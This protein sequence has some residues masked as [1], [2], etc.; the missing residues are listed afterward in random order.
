MAGNLKKLKLED[1]RI[2][3]Y[4]EYGDP[5]GIPILYNHG[6]LCGRDVE[7]A[8]QTALRMGVRII[9]PNR[10]GVGHSA[11]VAS[12]R[13]SDW[14]KDVG[15]LMDFLKI[16]Q[17]HVL[18]WSMGAPY[19]LAC[20]AEFSGRIRSVTIIGGVLPLDKE[21]NLQQ[22]GLGVQGYTRTCRERPGKAA[23]SFRLLRWL[24]K[25]MPKS[26]IHIVAQDFSQPDDSVIHQISIAR[27]CSWFIEASHQVPGMIEEYVAWAHPWGFELS[28]IF[29]PVTVYWA[30]SDQVVPEA[31]AKKI[32]GDVPRGTYLPQANGGHFFPLTRWEPILQRIIAPV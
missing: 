31:W 24:A 26:F 28:E 19:A 6:N 4:R 25:L 14:P 29:A 15:Q 20:G 3:A 30:P 23:F 2:L 16:N 7:T 21:E 22:L 9:S 27:Y 17:F 5:A 13:I 32:A 12:R 10:P 18:G 11:R 8:H 1:G